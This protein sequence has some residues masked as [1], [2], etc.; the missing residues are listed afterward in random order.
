MSFI[1]E[2]AVEDG[3]EAAAFFKQGGEGPESEGKNN[4][5]EIPGACA[6]FRK[7]VFFKETTDGQNGGRAGK[8]K[9]S[10]DGGT[11]EGEGR[12][13]GDQDENQGNDRRK[14]GDD[15]SHEECYF[16]DR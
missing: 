5:T 10:G 9:G 15:I 7:E 13:F 1:S 16:K 4:G 6:D 8:E 2:E 14:D 3:G 11:E 12:A